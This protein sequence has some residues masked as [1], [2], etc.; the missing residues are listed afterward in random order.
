MLAS[1]LIKP[2]FI[3]TTIIITSVIIGALGGINQTSLRK[4][5]T[6]SSINHTG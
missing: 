1:Y 6:Y 4:I 3:T 2:D 5:L